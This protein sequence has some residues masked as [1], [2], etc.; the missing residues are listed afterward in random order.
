[1]E[2]MKRRDEIAHSKAGP[3]EHMVGG[4]DLSPDTVPQIIG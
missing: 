1:M 4:W 3:A 2:Q